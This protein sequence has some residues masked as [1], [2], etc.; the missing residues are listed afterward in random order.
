MALITD[1]DLKEYLN[2]SGTSQDAL[3]TKIANRASAVIEDWLGRTIQAATYTEKHDGGDNFIVVKH[4]PINSITSLVDDSVTVATS[5]YVYYSESGIVKLKSGYFTSG[6]Q[7][8]EIT[9][10]GG[11][12]T[13][14]D[15]ITEAAIEL[16][17]LM[18]KE[19]DAGEGRLGKGS[20]SIPEGGTL[21]FIRKLNPMLIEALKRYRRV[22]V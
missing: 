13:V 4:T 17:S 2:I 12:S 22:N 7:K 10:N 18:Y 6:L 3:L 16:G 9:Y 19:L 21:S 14:P 15:V 1:S 8:V 5:K 11:Y 20:I